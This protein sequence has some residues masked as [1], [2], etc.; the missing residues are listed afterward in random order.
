MKLREVWKL[1]NTHGFEF[2]A[3]M[4]DGSRIHARV[5]LIDG[6]HRVVG[7]DFKQMAGWIP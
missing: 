6:L 7:V 4:L 2:T 3:V 1:P 5:E